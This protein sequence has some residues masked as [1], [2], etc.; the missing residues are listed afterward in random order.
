MSPRPDDTE[1]PVVDWATLVAGLNWRQGEHVSLIGPTGTGKSHLGL[2]LLSQRAWAVV[3]GTKPADPTLDRLR[4]HGY[5]LIREWPPPA[6]AQRVLLWP[7]WSNP[8]QEKAQA[9]AI[10]DAMVKMF[11]Q[12][13]WALF[14]D[15]VSWLCDQLGLQRELKAWWQ[16]GRSNNLTLVAATQRPAWVPRDIYS[17]ATHVFFWRTNDERDL[18]AIG[19]LGGLASATVRNLVSTLDADSHQF[20]YVNTRTG[21]MVRSNAPA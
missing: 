18:R 2:R 15:E 12:G 6:T 21:A 10:G 20:L 19:G 8:R 1:A 11:R 13:G 16:Q 17:A 9:E 5:R 14:A 7:K 4:R 3:L